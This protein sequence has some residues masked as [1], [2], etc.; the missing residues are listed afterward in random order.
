MDGS[1][2]GPLSDIRV[3]DMS[4]IF[5]G[6]YAGQILG[7]LGADVVKVERPPAGDEAR[8]YGQQKSEDHDGSAFVSLNRNKRSI[9]LDLQSASDSDVLWRLISRADVLLHNFRP[10]VMDR[11][12]FGYEQCHARNTGL[13]YCSISGYGSTGPRSG[14]AAND[15]T[16]QAYSGVLSITGEPAR[17]P[18]R[19][20]VSIA[21][22]TAGANAVI[23]ILAALYWR[24]VSGRGQLVE[25]SL[26]EGQLVLA[27]H[28][29]T[30]FKRNGSVPQR[31]G[32][33]N[34][35]GIPNQAFP[36]SD[37]WVCITAPNERSW[38]RCAAALGIPEAGED[39]RFATLSARYAHR[40]ELYELIAGRTQELTTMACLEELSR[41]GVPSA[42]VKLISDIPTDPQVEALARLFTMSDHERSD[43]MIKSPLHL[44]ATPVSYRC[45]PPRPGQEREII[46][47]ELPGV[48]AETRY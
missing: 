26:L 8:R 39:E 14:D 17:P 7:D 29:V 46:L 4:R 22:L 38:R 2:H 34:Q 28:F 24:N 32:T 18:S 25:T 40:E 21:D 48:A 47:R 12:G 42:S 37:G 3:V 23:G 13:V 11:L 5:A 20:P 30:E 19:I 16:I 45:Y 43:V 27:G 6:P 9:M 36:T 35:L 44:S 41:A 33:A 1:S 10:G 15:L 31:M